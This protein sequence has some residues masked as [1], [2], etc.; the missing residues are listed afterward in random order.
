[1]IKPPPSLERLRAALD[2]NPETG[3]FTWRRRDDM[4]AKWNTRY[5]GKRAGAVFPNG[6]RRIAIDDNLYYAQ[7]LA[8][9]YVTG[10]WPDEVDH[11]N[12]VRGDDRLENLRPASHAQNIA[13]TGLTARNKSGLK[14]VHWKAD[15]RKWRASIRVDGKSVSLGHFDCPA[16]GHFAYLVAADKHHGQFARVA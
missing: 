10:E 13:N 5:A 6:Y 4:P 7:R 2:Y 3:V 8:W 16:A 12:G 9:F 15:S 11:R 14:G 1:M